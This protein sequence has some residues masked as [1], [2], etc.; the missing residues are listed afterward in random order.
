M[1]V[2]QPEGLLTNEKLLP[3]VQSE[4]LE[5]CCRSVLHSSLCW[6]VSLNVCLHSGSNWT[7]ALLGISSLG[8]CA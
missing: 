8:L 7:G 3:P 6:D 2:P 4:T 5:L 1:E